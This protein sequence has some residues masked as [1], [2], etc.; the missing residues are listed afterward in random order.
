MK[1]ITGIAFLI[2]MAGVSPAL[3]C[4][5]CV[6]AML[7]LV[8]PPVLFWSALSLTWFL[9]MAIVSSIA[10]YRF[11]GQPSAPWALGIAV[12]AVVLGGGVLG[13]IA[14]IPLALPPLY[15]TLR[16]LRTTT[17]NVALARV[18]QIVLLIGLVHVVAGGVGIALLVQTLRTRTDAKYICEW[19]GTAPGLARFRALRQ[20][21]PGSIDAYRYIVQHGSGWIVAETAERLGNIGDPEHDADVLRLAR[22]NAKGDKALLSAIDAALQALQKRRGPGA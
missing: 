2:W 17:E 3:A 8:I 9:S 15:A 1:R 12:V 18:R 20:Q 16:A 21:E 6:A 5:V 7:D 14:V 11:R 4:G 19:S 13:P 22:T 10:G